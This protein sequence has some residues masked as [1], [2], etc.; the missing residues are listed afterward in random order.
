MSV[1]KNEWEPDFAGGDCRQCEATYR[2]IVSHVEVI[3]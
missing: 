2:L 3:E 1:A